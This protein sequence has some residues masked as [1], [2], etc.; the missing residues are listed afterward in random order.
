MP[1]AAGRRGE[2]AGAPSSSRFRAVCPRGTARDA[3][4]PGPSRWVRRRPDPSSAKKTNTDV[5]ARDQEGEKSPPLPRLR[6]PQGRGA[7]GKPAGLPG[8]RGAGRR[9]RSPAGPSSLRGV[10]AGPSPLSGVSPGALLASLCLR[11]SFSGAPV[12]TRSYPRSL[13]VPGRFPLTFF[14][15]GVKTWLGSRR[16][17]ADVIG[18]RPARRPRPPPPR[19]PPPPT[20]CASGGGGGG[21]GAFGG[22]RACVSARQPAGVCAPRARAGRHSHRG[23]NG[24][25]RAAA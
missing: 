17:P 14:F 2:P 12:P 19:S 21:G 25:S 6:A 10:R 1:G 24:G 8:Q 15:P 23:G 4:P 13:R 20:P 16:L 3:V 9:G 18:R 5:F 11:F 7:G 22:V